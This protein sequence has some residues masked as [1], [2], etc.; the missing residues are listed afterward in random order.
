MEIVFGVCVIIYLIIF[1]VN[2]IENDVIKLVAAD[3]LE[4]VITW[5]ANYRT[6]FSGYLEINIPMETI[7][8]TYQKSMQWCWQCICFITCSNISGSSTECE[9]FSRWARSCVLLHISV[10]RLNVSKCKSRHL[11]I[12]NCLC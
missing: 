7:S 5:F 12:Y 2:I 8:I 6:L 11:K 3:N 9:V 10:Y 1:T 4:E